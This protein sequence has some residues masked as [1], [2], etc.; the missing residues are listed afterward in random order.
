MNGQHDT[1]PDGD[2]LH[3]APQGFEMFKNHIAAMRNGS[4]L[5]GGEREKT[6]D[7]GTLSSEDK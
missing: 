5:L 4:W 6:Q 7:E 2:S 3:T 1:H